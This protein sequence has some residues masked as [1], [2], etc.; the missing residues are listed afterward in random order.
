MFITAVVGGCHIRSGASNAA[1]TARYRG[2]SPRNGYTTYSCVANDNCDNCDNEVHVLGSYESTQ[3]SFRTHPTGYPDVYLTVTGNSSRPL[4][5]VLSSYE[6][7]V[8]TLH[9][10]SGVAI[11]KVI[12]VSSDSKIAKLLSRQISYK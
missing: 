11:D 5:L 12:I 4:I 9:I 3:G 10:P 7:A 1:A 6:P 8:W 2:L